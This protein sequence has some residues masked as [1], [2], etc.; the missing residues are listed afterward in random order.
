MVAEREADVDEEREDDGM[1][2]VAHVSRLA[3][4][5]MQAIERLKRAP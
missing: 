3:Y 4:Q 2:A 5:T 1:F